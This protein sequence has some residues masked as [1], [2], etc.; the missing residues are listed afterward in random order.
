MPVSIGVS[1]NSFEN[2]IGLLSDCH[3]RIERFLQALLTVATHAAG[4]S[5]N[6]EYRS[7]LEAA[8]KYFREAAPKHTADEEEDLFPMLRQAAGD[9]VSAVLVGVDRLEGEHKKADRWHGQVEEICERWLVQD[10]LSS[11]EAA[12]LTDLLTS[13]ADLYRSHIAFEEQEVFPVAQAELSESARQAIA[14][15]MAARRGVPYQR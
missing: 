4:G 3:R 10:R 11:E 1:E 12:H 7:A 6:A 2:P 15:R 5:L 8:L 9:R 14:R 13:L